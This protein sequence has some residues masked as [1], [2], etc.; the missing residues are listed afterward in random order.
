MR[1]HVALEAHS[2]YISCSEHEIFGYVYT[3]FYI[4]DEGHSSDIKVTVAISIR[5]RVPRLNLQ[6][7]LG[8]R[9][10][11]RHLPKDKLLGV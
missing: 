8:V 4:V 11:A 1:V 5:S 10:L 6:D 9:D 2:A 7:V 3:H